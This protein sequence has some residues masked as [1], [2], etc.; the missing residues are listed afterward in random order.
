MHA[1]SQ[2]HEDGSMFRGELKRDLKNR[3]VEYFGLFPPNEAGNPIVENSVEWTSEKVQDLL[4]NYSY[5]TGT[6]DIAVCIRL[7]PI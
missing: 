1:L 4:R 7:L 2:V 5:T 6:R 3:L